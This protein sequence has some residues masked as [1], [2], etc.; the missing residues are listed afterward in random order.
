MQRGGCTHIKITNGQS[1]SRHTELAQTEDWP[2]DVDDPGHV[3][4]HVRGSHRSVAMDDDGHTIITVTAPTNILQ[5]VAILVVGALAVTGFLT[6]ANFWWS[7]SYLRVAQ[8]ARSPP[9][10]E[11]HNSPAAT[12]HDGTHLL[13]DSEGH[14]MS[15]S[16]TSFASPSS[17]RPLPRAPPSPRRPLLIISQQWLA[18]RIPPS[19]PPPPLQPPPVHPPLPPATP[20]VPPSPLSPPRL[21]WVKHEDTNCWWD[22]NGAD[23]ELETPL[24]S[25][26]P[27]VSSLDD[28][29]EACLHVRLCEGI[30]YSHQ[31]NCYRKGAITVENCRTSSDMDLHLIQIGPGPPSPP[32]LP[33]SWPWYESFGR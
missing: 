16:S 7:G 17:S 12:P 33:P 31:G 11:S 29:K 25:A 20:P 3:A 10:T 22:G 26:A 28:C 2:D 5:I 13:T 24:G 18:S 8:Q 6:I 4:V 9:A 15:D 14:S 21:Y 23:R 1:S 32:P 30:L 19:L 27:G